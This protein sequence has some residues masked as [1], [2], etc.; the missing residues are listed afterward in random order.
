[1]RFP[2][3]RQ[4]GVKVFAPILFLYQNG[5]VKILKEAV[6]MSNAILKNLLLVPSPAIACCEYDAAK[7]AYVCGGGGGE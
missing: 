3:M 2:P 5:F 4:I 7:D 6:F 1:M